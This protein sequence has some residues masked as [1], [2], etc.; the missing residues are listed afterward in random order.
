M[1]APSP[2]AVLHLA[3]LHT[4]AATGFASTSR[5]ASIT[6]SSTLSRYLRLVAVTCTERASLAGRSKVAAIDVLQALEELGVGGVGEL[7]EW[8]VGL[9]QEVSL[10]A[11][12][13]TALGEEIREG[14]P[15]EESIARLK[16]V[17]VD[18]MEM[19]DDEAN[20]AVD[21]DEEEDEMDVDVKGDDVDVEHDKDIAERINRSLRFPSPD[22]SWLPPLPSDDLGHEP[23]SASATR[24]DDTSAATLDNPSATST[25]PAASLSIIDRYRRRIPFS[26]SQLSE[27]RP[28]VDPPAPPL[29]YPLPSTPSSFPALQTAFAAT[30]G[31]PTISLRQTALRQ[32]A[33]DLLRRTIASPDEYSPQDTLVLPLAGPRSTPIIPSYSLDETI[34][35]RSIPIVSNPDG[36]LS[37]LVHEMR[38]P[39]LPPGLRERLTSVRPPQPQQKDGEPVLYGQPVRGPGEAALARAKGKPIEAD[40]A[41]QGMLQATWKTP[42]KGSERWGKR[43]QIGKTVVQSGIGEDRPRVPEGSRPAGTP[44]QA[45]TGA[46][47]G[48]AISGDQGHTADQAGSTAVTPGGS[49]TSKIKFRLS[50]TGAMASPSDSTI[51]HGSGLSPNPPAQRSPNPPPSSAGGLSPNPPSAPATSPGAGPT[52]LKLKLGIP[53]RPSQS[54]GSM[55]APPGRNGSAHLSPNHRPQSSVSPAPANPS[56]TGQSPAQRPML[57]LKLGSRSASPY[58]TTTTE[59]QTPAV[60]TEP[61]E[62][63]PAGSA[64]AQGGYWKTNGGY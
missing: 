56:G 34:P 29:P 7:Q 49:T 6:L 26:Q 31:E 24:N 33:S 51:Q 30:K 17:P 36:I 8:A 40:K 59:N 38:T 43:L 57:S 3:A 19:E 5:A 28:F 46:P 44:G 11:P 62:H 2:D 21:E 48:G 61:R 58:T 39:H 27:I 9:D 41:G 35:H 10:S 12:G 60:K 45:P 52:G 32:Q 20:S 37:R 63:R 22:L 1:T 14:L 42:A 50:T 54:E 64:G 25:A 23:T 16:M 13:L 53:K 55:P 47:M 4:L 15:V 18:E